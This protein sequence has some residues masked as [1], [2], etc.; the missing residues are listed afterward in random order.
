M[1]LERSRVSGVNLGSLKLLIESS[2]AADPS[3]NTKLEYFMMLYMAVAF[4]FILEI[5]SV[6]YCF[7]VSLFSFSLMPTCWASWLNRPIAIIFSICGLFFA[8]TCFWT[9]LLKEL[10][11]ILSFKMW[12]SAV[13][14]I[15]LALFV[16]RPRITPKSTLPRLSKF[17]GSA[18]ILQDS[19]KNS[20]K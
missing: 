12:D 5:S 3:F 11:K 20:W 16:L 1:T 18:L 2:R 4:Y 17:E 6:N 15:E 8:M 10:I 13:N 7:K 9:N 19:S 14:S